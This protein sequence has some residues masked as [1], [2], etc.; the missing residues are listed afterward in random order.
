MPSE[1]SLRAAQTVMQLVS[2]AEAAQRVQPSAS[3][4]AHQ[5]VRDGRA[6]TLT[7]ESSEFQVTRIRLFS[8]QHAVCEL[9]VAECEGHLAVTSTVI[10]DAAACA[11][12]L[13]KPED[14][15]APMTNDSFDPF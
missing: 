13:A 8:G 9:A 1:T 6:F 12:F 11:S 4:W 10:G 3:H 2:W 14:F 5:V 15:A 7:A